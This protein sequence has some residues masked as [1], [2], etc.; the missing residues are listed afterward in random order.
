MEAA[1]LVVSVRVDSPEIINARD[2]GRERIL[3]IREI[4]SQWLI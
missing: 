2:F 4:G 3:L 1:T